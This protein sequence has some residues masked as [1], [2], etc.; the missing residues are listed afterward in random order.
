MSR[1]T[2]DSRMD[3]IADSLMR[4][5]KQTV[6]DRIVKGLV[7]D[8]QNKAKQVVRDELEKVTIEGLSRGLNVMKMR[9]ELEIKINFGDNDVVS[10]TINNL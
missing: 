2:V 10:H 3:F 7:E 8:F 1:V 9:E 4:D 5:L 6:E